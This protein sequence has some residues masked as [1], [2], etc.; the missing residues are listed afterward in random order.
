MHAVAGAHRPA[1][2]LGD[3]R[4]QPPS[5]TVT[6][7]HCPARAPRRR[8]SRHR[9]PRA[10][11][12]DGRDRRR[13]LGG[14]PAPCSTPLLYHLT[15]HATPP[16]PHNPARRPACPPCSRACPPYRQAAG[17]ACN[18]MYLARQAAGPACNPMYLARRATCS[19]SG[20]R[21]RDRPPPPRCPPRRA[22]RCGAASSGL[23]WRR[24]RGRRR[25]RGPARGAARPRSVSRR[26]HP[27]ARTPATVPSD[28]CNP[29]GYAC[30]PV[31]YACNR[32]C[33]RLQPYPTSL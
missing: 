27:C 21:A 8:R 17:P 1:R 18:L 2:T 12:S 31:G 3:I 19:P 15:P 33:S 30:C 20:S 29:V 26:L 7:G 9:W 13:T 16:S 14:E 6:G 32:M 4:L 25:G 28:A 23:R 5:H 10:D 11:R 24:R 22:A